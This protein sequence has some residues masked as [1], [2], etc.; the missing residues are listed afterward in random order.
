MDVADGMDREPNTKSNGRGV[1][2]SYGATDGPTLELL[3]SPGTIRVVGADAVPV[4]YGILT[5][6][7]GRAAAETTEVLNALTITAAA[8]TI[9][10]IIAIIRVRVPIEASGYGTVS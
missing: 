8:S 6:T 1:T 7:V 10:I 4:R 9:R 3:G 5:V 2:P